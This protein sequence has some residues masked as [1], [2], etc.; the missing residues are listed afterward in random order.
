MWLRR[1]CGFFAGSLMLVATLSLVQQSAQSVQV[2]DS[3]N[4][5]Q[6]PQ[7]VEVKTFEKGA[8][9][10][11]ATYYLTISVPEQAGAPLQRLTLT[12]SQ[13]TSQIQFVA[14]QTKAYQSQ[15][16]QAQVGVKLID[17]NLA[18]RTTAIR[19]EPAIAPG[20]TVTVALRPTINP[21][22]A[23][24]YQFG[25]TAFPEGDQARG[26]FLGVARL[27]FY[28]RGGRGQG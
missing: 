3:A 22:I 19:F 21:A 16:R 20:Q 9:S 5:A 15:N 27:Q 8:G 25:V 10:L 2:A 18:P 11:I 24:T 6:V 13:G 12:Q 4:F 1:F 28:N 26:Q 7:L 23:G 14:E 17:Q